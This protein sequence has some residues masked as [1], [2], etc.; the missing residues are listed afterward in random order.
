MDKY[1]TDG[2]DIVMA[3]CGNPESI[4]RKISWMLENTDQ[5]N[6]ITKRGYD[7]AN[8]LLEYKNSVNRILKL[9]DFSEA[10]TL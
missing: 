8:Q 6:L 7:K 3:E 2:H 9:L 10:H 1:F 5:L 4:A